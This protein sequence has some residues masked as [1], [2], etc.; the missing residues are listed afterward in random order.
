MSSYDLNQEEALC[1]RK[2]GDK[3]LQKVPLAKQEDI[4]SGSVIEFSQRLADRLLNPR[5]ECVRCG[6]PE[7]RMETTGLWD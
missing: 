2:C 3:G 6:E 5:Y 7:L 1:C 4:A